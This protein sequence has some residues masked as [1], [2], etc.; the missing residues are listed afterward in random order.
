MKKL[1]VRP[2]MKVFVS[3]ASADKF[4]AGKIIEELRK[5]NVSVWFDEIAIRVGQSIPEAIAQGLSDASILCV[6]I[7]KNSVKSTWVSREL[8]S[9]L[10]KAMTKNA[11]IIPCRIDD[12]AIPILISDIKY[13]DFTINFSAGMSALCEA[14]TLHELIRLE[15]DII[16]AH[17]VLAIELSEADISDL[18]S[19]CRTSNH[20]LR[21][22]CRD[23]SDNFPS[24]YI[25]KLERLNLMKRTHYRDWNDYHSTLL[26]EA[27]FARIARERN[28]EPGRG[29]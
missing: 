14:V 28:L 7:S 27:V 1:H 23:L 16:S 24:Q 17:H 22:H 29:P 9:F 4:V 3:H 5:R 10:H 25:T 6:L 8:N 13:A 18:I 2:G 11:T 20:G 26:G 12:S 15:T 19:R 21:F